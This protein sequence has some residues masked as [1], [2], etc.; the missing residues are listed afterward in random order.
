MNKCAGL[1]VI[2]DN[3]SQTP[4][5]LRGGVNKVR[6]IRGVILVR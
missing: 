1:N 4:L 3:P 6:E 2:E 5:I